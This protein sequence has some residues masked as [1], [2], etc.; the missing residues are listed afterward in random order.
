MEF[1]LH[2]LEAVETLHVARAVP[3]KCA[4]VSGSHNRCKIEMIVFTMTLERRIHDVIYE[5][6]TAECLKHSGN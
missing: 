3:E 6:C 4:N 1:G 5:I 2:Q